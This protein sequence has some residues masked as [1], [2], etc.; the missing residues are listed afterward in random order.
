VTESRHGPGGRCRRGE[1]GDAEN[2]TGADGVRLGLLNRS[3][4]EY[5]QVIEL[6]AI[7]RVGLLEAVHEGSTLQGDGPTNRVHSRM[8]EHPGGGEVE[9]QHGAF[10]SGAVEDYGT[11]GE[12][13]RGE[14]AGVA[15]GRGDPAGA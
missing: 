8:A 3:V 11:S 7:R 4:G 1:G 5:A 2:R 9:L 12:F 13:L 6:Y 15:V 10:G 14:V